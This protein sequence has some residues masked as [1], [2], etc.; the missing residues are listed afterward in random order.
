MQL[1]E[2]SP[3]HVSNVHYNNLW[4]MIGTFCPFNLICT[5]KEV[6]I[7]VKIYQFSL[8][9]QKSSISNNRIW[10]LT[11]F[12]Q[13]MD[14]VFCSYIAVVMLK[15]DVCMQKGILKIITLKQIQ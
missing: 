9:P 8:L 13:R 14:L 11:C 2:A 1:C 4:G 7:H 15:L 10:F 6:H 5:S 3:F 12:Y